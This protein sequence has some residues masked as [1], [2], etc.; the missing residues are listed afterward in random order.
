VPKWRAHSCEL[1]S[2]STQDRPYPGTRW[3]IGRYLWS[4]DLS[5]RLS[6]ARNQPS[7]SRELLA[8]GIFGGKSRGFKSRL[9]DR[10]EVLLRRGRTFSPR[11]SVVGVIASAVILSGLLLAGSL[12]PR[13]IAFAQQQPLPSFEVASIK[14]NNSG[15]DRV[16]GGFQ[17]GGRYR[18]TNYTLR[19]LIAA[20]YV[21]PQV[22]PDFLI[23]DGPKWIDSDRFDVDAKAAADFPAGPDG[24]STPR[25]M[26]LQALLADRFK[27]KVHSETRQR[28]TYELTF[29]KSDRTMGPKLHPSSVDC[30]GPACFAKIGPGSIVIAGTTIPRFVGLL[31]RF[32]DRVVT[33]ATGLAGSFDLELT[34]TPAP[35]E[36]VAPPLPGGVTAAPV[37]GPSIF[38]AIQEQLGLKLQSQTGPVDMLVIDRVEKPDAN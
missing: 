11:A 16:S 30:P 3:P 5:R 28:P 34:W 18:V 10:I 35:G 17:P 20:A 31:P 21:R 14:P 7:Q 33:D 24:P 38:T 19:S 9:G 25:R 37:D 23:A 6:P 8:V 2:R 32:T 13:W 26:M 12:A 22:N 27:L 36:W 29:A 4:G 15:D 1:A